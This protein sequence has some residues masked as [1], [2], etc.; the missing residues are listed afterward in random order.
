[1]PSDELKNQIRNSYLRAKKI[2]PD[3]KPR[4]SQNLMIAEIAKTISNISCKNI[5]IEA[6]TGV[7]KTFAYL[8][9]SIPYALTNKKK[10]VISTANIALQEQLINKDLPL[11]LKYLDFKFSYS[12]AK[13]RSRYLCVRNLINIVE[14]GNEGFSQNITLFD[15]KPSTFDIKNLN[16]YLNDY[17]AQNWDGDIDNL[18]IPPRDNIWSKISCNRFTCTSRNCEFYQDCCFFKKR[19]IIKESDVVITNHDL[20]ITD[21]INGNNVLPEIEESILILDEVHHLNDRS[22]KH[23]KYQFSIINMNSV[24]NQSITI[25]N[26]LKSSIE[27]EIKDFDKDEILEKIID[28][29]NAVKEQ[30]FEDDRVIFP[31][32]LIDNQILNILID[33]NKK[34]Q[35]LKTLLLTVIEKWEEYKK[36]HSINN[37]EKENLDV[38][39]LDNSSQLESILL[40]IEYFLKRSDNE[41]PP[42]AK[43]IRQIIQPQN[44]NNFLFSSASINISQNFKNLIWKVVHSSILTSATIS[45]LGNFNRLNQQLGLSKEIAKYLRLPSPFNLEKVNFIIPKLRSSPKDSFEH[46]KEISTELIKRIN[47]SEGTLVL[48]ASKTQMDQVAE[49]I[50]D[51][52]DAEIL[53]QGQ[54]QKNVILDLHSEKIASGYGSIIFGL[55]SFSEGIDLKGKALSHVIISKLRFS[56]PN[57]PIEKTQNAYLQSI[58]QNAFIEISLPDAT[59]KLIQACGRLI[60]SENDFG[61]ITIFDKRLVSEFYGKRILNSLPGYNIV[62]E[63]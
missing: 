3:F 41:E 32:E 37:S 20:L 43:W 2:I 1:M 55:D 48:F 6:P 10:V 39:I 52:L 17:S 18:N 26:K 38:L 15:E 21:L 50:E 57:S 13:G 61:R 28:L 58:G 12:L 34:L 30:N 44:K 8:I 9:S 23:F 45:S 60:R 31:N 24:I 63:D 42:M 16:K 53:V 29:I 4:P 51:K 47:P 35:A 36:T 62:I 25:I 11:A 54:Y 49:N 14:D 46:T 27:I 22:L 59:L 33:I 56:I 7:G 19:K 40:G 5:V